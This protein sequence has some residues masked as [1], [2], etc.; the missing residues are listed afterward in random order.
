MRRG[1]DYILLSGA[2]LSLSD[3]NRTSNVHVRK[4]KKKSENTISCA[5]DGILS[6]GGRKGGGGNIL[7]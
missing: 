5:V 6:N 7:R 3:S 4:E 1:R 2:F